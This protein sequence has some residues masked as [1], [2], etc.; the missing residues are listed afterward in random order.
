VCVCVRV[1]VSVVK[2][3]KVRFNLSF[4]LCTYSNEMVRTFV[5]FFNKPFK[6]SYL[7]QAKP[8]NAVIHSHEAVLR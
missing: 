2:M 4:G 5:F 1:S 6:I 8:C 3:Q 7:T